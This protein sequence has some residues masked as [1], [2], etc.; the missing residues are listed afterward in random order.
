MSELRAGAAT[1]VITPR[2]G[3]RIT[4]LFRTR[5]A[6]SIEDELRVRAVVLSNDTGSVA[7]VACDLL[8][9]PAS[10][11]N[12]A[13]QLIVD[14]TGI[15]PERVM[16]SATHTHFGPP[17]IRNHRDTPDPEW[18]DWLVRQIADAVARA[19][20]R[21][22]PAAVSH[23]AATVDNVCFNRRYHMRNGTV[24]FNPGRGNPDIVGPAGP[25]DP[26]VTAL[27]VEGLDGKP[28]AVWSN[29]SLHYVGADDASAFSPDYYGRF[30]NTVRRW[31][32]PDAVGVLTNAASGDINNTD[33]SEPVA[34]SP[35]AQA[36]QVATAVAGAAIGSTFSRPRDPD[37]VIDA[38]LFTRQLDRWPVTEDDVAIAAEI[39]N[40]SADTPLPPGPFSFVTGQEIPPGMRRDYAESLPLLAA[41][42]ASGPAAM[43]IVRI[44]DLAI[45][46]MPGE[47]FV[48]FGI[49]L[50]K[51]S[52][53]GRTAVV[54]LANDYLGYL[55]TQR[56][57]SQGGYET[58]RNEYA[59]TRPGA[60]EAMVEEIAARLP[61][62][63]ARS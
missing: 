39:R 36:Q 21:R 18:I 12:A 27:L 25:T 8:A 19:Y 2:L 15:S 4:G 35:S 5:T 17:T 31:L 60:G 52:P 34:A 62:L 47:V 43:Q 56:A 32:G 11:V 55:P 28:I 57:F 42:P 50:R 24:R 38:E 14:E 20:A 40:A 53:F 13:K 63:H 23:G 33:V 48:E 51:L 10:V 46:G 54:G 61:V 9:V 44:G 41:L 6:T 26:T 7:L 59:W 22:R 1:T 30:G 58:W 37:P 45:I 16:I 3:T 49:Q 29:L